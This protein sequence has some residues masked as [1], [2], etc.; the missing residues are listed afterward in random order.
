M[1]RSLDVFAPSAAEARR[2]E[3]LGK[4]FFLA[5]VDGVREMKMTKFSS[6]LTRLIR[7]ALVAAWAVT[8][9]ALSTF[10]SF[11]AMQPTDK[12]VA[13]VIGNGAYQNAV[14]LDNAVFDAR[15]V[16]DAFRKLGFQVVEGYDLDIDQ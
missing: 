12:R 3:T 5:V 4:R 10:P 1:S 2:G 16:A 8:V 7:A 13:L 14:R 11:A 6:G 15:A 9:V